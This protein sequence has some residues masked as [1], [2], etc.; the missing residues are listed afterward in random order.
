MP[1]HILLGLSLGFILFT[2]ALAQSPKVD[3]QI[4]DTLVNEAGDDTDAVKE[5]DFRLITGAKELHDFGIKSKI[6]TPIEHSFEIGGSYTSS[7][8]LKDNSTTLNLDDVTTVDLGYKIER[9]LL[10]GDNLSLSGALSQQA[11]YGR[12]N[13]AQ[14]NGAQVGSTNFRQL[15]AYAD[16]TAR[17]EQQTETDWTPFVSA[18]VGVV[19]DRVTLDGQTFKDLSPVGRYRA[20]L[21]KKINDSTT[22]GIGVGQSFKLD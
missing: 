21:E 14:L 7:V 6:D 12:A 15:G 9:D 1:K 11:R 13:D 4:E 5:T 22:F 17:V 18:G 20:G 3:A 8:T 19:H 16:L 2:P 10:R